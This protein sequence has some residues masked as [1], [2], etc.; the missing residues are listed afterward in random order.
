MTRHCATRSLPSHLFTVRLWREELEEGRYEWRG[1]V[2]HAL[3]GETRYFR[4]WEDLIAFVQ[5]KGEGTTAP[6]K[7]DS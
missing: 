6:L 5:E 3:S 7:P 2:Q 4:R 1:K